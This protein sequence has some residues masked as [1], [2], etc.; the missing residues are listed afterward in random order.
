M[1]LPLCNICVEENGTFSEI[2][3]LIYFGKF[4]NSSGVERKLDIGTASKP[5]EVVG[6]WCH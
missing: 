4:Q 5:S 2:L 1:F 3:F 6:Y